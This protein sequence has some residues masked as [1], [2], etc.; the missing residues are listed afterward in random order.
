[1]SADMSAQFATLPVDVP[2]AQLL[3]LV[4]AVMREQ[5]P[6]IQVLEQL[7][8]GGYLPWPK[9]HLP[10]A[11]QWTPEQERA[12]AEIVTMDKVRRV[13]IGSLEITELIRR[14][15]ARDIS[16]AGVA[17]LSLSTSPGVSS[18]S[19]PFGGEQWP[20]SFWFKVNAELIL[21]GS[22]EPD[23]TVTVGGR[24]I[25]L[26]PDGTFSYRFALPDGEYGLPAVATSADGTD[27][28]RADLHFGRSTEY[29]GDVGTHPQDAVLKP[30]RAEHLA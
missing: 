18:I 4:K 7:R 24:T 10:P 27:A 21:Y 16:S 14:Q 29:S 8:A 23:A 6:L 17:Q 3:Q 1:M 12:L 19:S 11:G 5:S 15:L 26:R 9:K 20:K 25:K 22:T 30:P 2:F 28:R 13:W